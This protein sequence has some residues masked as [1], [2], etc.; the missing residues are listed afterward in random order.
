MATRLMHS[1]VLY[2]IT[3]YGKFTDL[4]YTEVI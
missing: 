4:Y 2:I 1:V 3:L